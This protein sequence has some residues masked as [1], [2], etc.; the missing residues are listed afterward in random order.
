MQF[1]HLPSHSCAVTLIVHQITACS[2]YTVL[3]H[4]QRDL[5]FHQYERYFLW[6]ANLCLQGKACEAVSGLL[7]DKKEIPT[8]VCDV[9]RSETA[10]T[11][12]EVPCYP[13]QY[14]CWSEELAKIKF[15]NIS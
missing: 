13:I 9:Y 7:K 5:S 10:F 3:R 15:F 8:G 6:C 12:K 4:T 1:N 14:A 2:A 11:L